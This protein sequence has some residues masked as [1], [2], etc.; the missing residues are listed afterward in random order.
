L[1]AFN[2]FCFFSRQ[3]LSE[4]PQKISFIRMKNNPETGFKNPDFGP[5][6]GFHKKVG[7]DPGPGVR[8]LSGTPK[9]IPDPGPI[10]SLY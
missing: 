4:K 6:H 9:K 5:G 7:P 2:T 3:N 8:D 10:S 1:L